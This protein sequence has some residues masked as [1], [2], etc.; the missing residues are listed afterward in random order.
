MKTRK[1]AALS[2]L[3]AL[4]LILSYVESMVPAPV[5]V[6]G[7]KLGLA[8]LA[9]VF[10]LYALGFRAAAMISLV[11]VAAVAVLFGSGVSLLYS[12]AGAVLA[13]AVMGALKAG[14][15]FSSVAVSVAGGVAHNAGQ[16]LVA[17]L[18]LRTELFTYYLPFLIVSGVITGAAIG[19]VSGILVR[20]VRWKRK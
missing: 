9:V 2:L 14:G 11:R 3:T 10:A 15:R 8:N 18:L 5:P 7:V 19:A 17:S 13:L 1:L 6:P 4:A 16:I 20:R 12:L